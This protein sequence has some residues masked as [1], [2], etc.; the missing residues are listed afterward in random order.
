M[1]LK[2]ETFCKHWLMHN[3]L[4]MMARREKNAEQVRG[5]PAIVLE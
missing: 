1:V 5:I 3:R 2:V 4:G